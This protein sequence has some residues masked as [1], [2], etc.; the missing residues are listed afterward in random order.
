[1][2]GLPLGQ[3]NG[4]RWISS[5]FRKEMTGYTE[6]KRE[7]NDKEKLVKTMHFSPE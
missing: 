6:D 2:V 5:V 3:R 4:N 7:I 1:M